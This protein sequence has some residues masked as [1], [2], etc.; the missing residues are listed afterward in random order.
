MQLQVEKEVSTNKRAFARRGVLTGFVT[1][2][3]CQARRA[4]ERR[5]EGLKA[6]LDGKTR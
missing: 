5:L 4:A 6:S 3:F 1:V 2:F